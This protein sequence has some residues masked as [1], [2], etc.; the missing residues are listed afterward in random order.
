MTVLQHPN[1]FTHGQAAGAE[2][3]DEVAADGSKQKAIVPDATKLP[4]PFT[5]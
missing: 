3:H 1:G 5:T 2:E 4:L